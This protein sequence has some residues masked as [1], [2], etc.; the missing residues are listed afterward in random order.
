MERPRRVCTYP[1][2]QHAI[3]KRNSR[4]ST[5]FYEFDSIHSQLTTIV[6]HLT[7]LTQHQQQE[8]EY[9]DETQDWKF[10]AMVIDRLCLII[11]TLSMILFTFL[12]LFR[13]TNF[14][15]LQ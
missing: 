14:L 4:L 10:V 8:E 9:D 3:N 12:T 11:F 2:A 1:I 15:K 7:A 5:S 6:N 13:H